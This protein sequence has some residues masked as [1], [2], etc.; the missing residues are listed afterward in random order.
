MATCEI[1]GVESYE[2]VG[3]KYSPATLARSFAEVGNARSDRR[4]SAGFPPHRMQIGL[5]FM[6]FRKFAR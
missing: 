6:S 1:S 4:V 3:S 2:E 5:S